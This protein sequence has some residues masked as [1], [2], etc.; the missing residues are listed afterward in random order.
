MT[1]ELDSFLNAP[2]QSP[3]APDSGSLSAEDFKILNDKVV[4]LRA[5]AEKG[6]VLDKE[7]LRVVVS[8]YRASLDTAFTLVKTKAKA[9]ARAK[10]APRA[11]SAAALKKAEAQKKAEALMTLL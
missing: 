11:P 5:R 9:K 6:E 2:A 10:P 1:S 4:K 3:D 7:D 8:W